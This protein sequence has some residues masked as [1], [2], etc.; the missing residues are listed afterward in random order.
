MTLSV[1][2]AR[3]LAAKWRPQFQDEA[4]FEH[5]WSRFFEMVGDPDAARLEFWLAKDQAKD[6]VKSAG[7]VREPLLPVRQ[8]LPDLVD[9]CGTCHGKRW[10]R[11]E[12]PVGHHEFGKALRCPACHGR[13]TA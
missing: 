3:D 4:N 9:D 2:E 13:V 6:A 7:I 11:R 12:L 5:S 1:D 8:D 10:V